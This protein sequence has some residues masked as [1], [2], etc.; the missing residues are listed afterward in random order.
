MVTSSIAGVIGAP[1]SGSYTGK[2][3]F[4]HECPICRKLSYIFLADSEKQ[5]NLL[6][7]PLGYT[8]KSLRTREKLAIKNS[9]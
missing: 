8:I 5:K 7:T 1:Y 3:C 2:L 6:L 4:L 9:R